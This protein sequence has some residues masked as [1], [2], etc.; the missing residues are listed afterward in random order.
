MGTD[1]RIKLEK[2]RYPKCQ[3]LE[4]NVRAAIAEV[5]LDLEVGHFTDVNKIIEYGVFMTPALVVDGIF[6]LVGKV[7]SKEDVKKLLEE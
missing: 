1:K 4:K 3:A 5:G 7:A 6:K 2:L